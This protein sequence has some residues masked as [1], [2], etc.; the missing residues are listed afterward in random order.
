MKLMAIFGVTAVHLSGTIELVTGFGGVSYYHLKSANQSF[1]L[2][3]SNAQF[4]WPCKSGE[5]YIIPQGTPTRYFAIVDGAC[6]DEIHKFEK[7][8]L[9]TWKKC[10]SK[11][12]GDISGD[13]QFK[14][15]Y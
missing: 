5:F 1:P 7:L 15:G 14:D 13:F 6:K 9:S 11:N 3:R 2:E 8:N 12:Q 4:Y 10:E